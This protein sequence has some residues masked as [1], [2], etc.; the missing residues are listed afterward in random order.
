M[1]GMGW[2]G[3]TE[4]ETLDTTIPSIELAMRGRIEMLKI[5]HGSGTQPA[6]E[7]VPPDPQKVFAVFRAAGAPK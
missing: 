1:D 4:Q 7:P 6:S 5:T 2:L 3:W